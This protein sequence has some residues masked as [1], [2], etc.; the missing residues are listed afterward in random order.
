MTKAYTRVTKITNAGGRSDYISNEKR[1]EEI[2]LKKSKMKYSWKE[3]S[4]FEKANKKTD[5]ENNEAREIIIPIPNE[6]AY[7]KDLSHFC[8][9]LK[10]QLVPDGHDYEYAVHWNKTRTNLHVHILFSERANN[11]ELKPKVYK[12]DIWQDE[13][14]NMAKAN[15]DGAILKCEK[16]EIQ[17]DKEG[18]IKYEA[19]IFK[20]KN[21]MFKSKEYTVLGIQKKTQK[22]F[23]QFGFEIEITDFDSPFLSQKRWKRGMKEE[24]IEDIKAYNKTA[25]E[26][27][28]AV[29]EHIELDPTIEEEYIELKRVNKKENLSGLLKIIKKIRENIEVFREIRGGISERFK[30]I[31]ERRDRT[32]NRTVGEGTDGERRISG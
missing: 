16:G 1:Q 5:K 14:G 10:Y 21:T 12:R 9:E 23:K 30:N 3:H 31:L 26:Y 29:K 6:M 20:P 18:N 4:A 7:R 11:L 28:Q 32:D 24:K 19:D 13:N 25:K 22:V 17:K 27:N 2:V 8:N 15:A